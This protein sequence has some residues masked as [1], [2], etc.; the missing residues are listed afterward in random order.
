MKTTCSQIEDLVQQYLDRDLNERQQQELLDHL[1][2]CQACQ[3]GYRPLLEAIRDVEQAAAPRVPAR[4]LE[5]VLQELPAVEVG[6]AIEAAPI[7]QHR[8]RLIPWFS[9]VAAAA[10]I[11]L[12]AVSRMQTGVVSPTGHRDMAAENTDPRAMMWLASAACTSPIGAGQPNLALVA[13]QAAAWHAQQATGEPVHVVLC[14]ARPIPSDR[15]DAPAVS[16]VLQMISN[17]AALHGGM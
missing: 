9:G 8:S 10:A 1:Q 2:H 16:D 11:L 4:L 15:P 14:M 7:R 5:R 3:A 12:I 6:P 13:G 17:R